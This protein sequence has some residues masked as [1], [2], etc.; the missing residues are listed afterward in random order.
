MKR[1]KEHLCSLWPLWFGTTSSS[2]VNLETFL[3]RMHIQINVMTPKRRVSINNKK[4]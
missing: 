4:G 2:T 1:D 3:I